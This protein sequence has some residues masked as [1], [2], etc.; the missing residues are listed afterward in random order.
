MMADVDIEAAG[1]EWT[2]TY[3]GAIRN[4]TRWHELMPRSGIGDT[5]LVL[6]FQP[7]PAGTGKGWWRFHVR[8]TITGVEREL[9]MHGVDD[10]EAFFAELN[11]TPAEIW[12]ERT[13]GVP[14]LED[15]AARGFLATFRAADA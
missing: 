9:L 5:E 6:P 13:A 3:E 2:N 11:Y 8:H 12:N 15:F 7:E 14:R 4:A 1:R 10:F